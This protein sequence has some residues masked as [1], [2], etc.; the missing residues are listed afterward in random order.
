VIFSPPTGIYN[1]YFIH[2][3]LTFILTCIIRYSTLDAR[4]SESYATPPRSAVPILASTPTTV[5]LENADPRS[6]L[7]RLQALQA[8]TAPSA[9]YC[10]EP[11][12]EA[13]DHGQDYVMKREIMGKDYVMN[14]RIASR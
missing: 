13:G 7:L 11:V 2:Y 10:K 1:V 3:Y 4:S 9:A 5:T 12:D 6:S 8:A 14:H